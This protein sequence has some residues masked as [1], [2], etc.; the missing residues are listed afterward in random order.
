M[1]LDMAK[2]KNRKSTICPGMRERDAAR[3]STLGEHFTSSH[4]RFL[5]DTVYRDL[6]LAIGW[7]EHKCK[8]WD[9]LAQEDYT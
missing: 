8:E 5:R 2:R 7:T 4:D 3:K 6:Q 9:A 1:V